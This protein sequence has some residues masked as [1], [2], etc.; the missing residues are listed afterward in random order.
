MRKI[1]SLT[2]LLAAAAFAVF[3]ATTGYHLIKQIKVG[4][5][6]GWDYPEMDSVGRRLYL[7]HGTHVAVVD[8]D[9]G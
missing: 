5:E 3:G 2:A 6:G 8:P 9:A 7:S 1:I 4:G